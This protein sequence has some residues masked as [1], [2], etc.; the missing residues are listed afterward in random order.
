M[1][2]YL[3][4]LAYAFDITSHSSVS[5]LYIALQSIFDMVCQKATVQN[6]VVLY[7][8]V[9]QEGHKNEVLEHLT[10]LMKDRMAVLSLNLC[11][12]L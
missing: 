4:S 8:K 7:T 9:L 3:F 5:F 2:I 1:K 6:M 10:F 12:S 11:L